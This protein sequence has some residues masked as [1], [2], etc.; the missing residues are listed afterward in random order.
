VSAEMQKD[1]VEQ[2]ADI[3]QRVRTELARGEALGP[4]ARLEALT[5]VHE[6]LEAELDQAAPPRR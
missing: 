6:W 2:A 1:H 3:S 4:E 5:R